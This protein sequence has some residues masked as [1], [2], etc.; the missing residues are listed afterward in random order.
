MSIVHHTFDKELSL[1]MGGA[2]QRPTVAYTTYGV[3]SPTKDNVIV[4]CHA[5]TANSAVKEWWGD[6]FGSD[7][8]FDPDKDYIICINNLGSP[9]GTSSPQSLDPAGDRYGLD[10]PDFT[11]RDTAHLQCRLLEHLGISE[12]KLLIGGSC[13]GNIALEMAIILGDKVDRLIALC[14]S[15]YE[16]PWVISIHESQRIAIEVD[17]TFTDNNDTAGREGLKGARAFAMPF[18]RSH[19]SFKLRQ[20]EDDINKVVDFKASSYVR[21]QGEKFI[22]RYDAQCYYKQL[23]ALDTHN[24]GR[25]RSSIENALR[26]IKAKTLMIGFS[27]DLLIPSIEQRLVADHIPEALFIE[28]DTLY[29]HDAFL[30]ETTKIQRSIDNWYIKS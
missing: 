5:L 14:C 27:S 30:I 13:G 18:Y 6:L 26:M 20:Q 12:I 24:L 19:P 25:G 1:E 15:A 8:T 17:S 28:I 4:V 7:R 3:L 2:L 21:Y 9:Y 22:K 29:G 10:F 11:L 16:T 23:I